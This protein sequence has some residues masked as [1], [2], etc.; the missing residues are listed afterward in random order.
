ME[1]NGVG[2]RPSLVLCLRKITRRRSREET[3]RKANLPILK[4]NLGR[5]MLS[6]VSLTLDFIVDEEEE[7]SMAEKN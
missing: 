6:P 7:K 4:P 5:T 3:R 2:R 1:C